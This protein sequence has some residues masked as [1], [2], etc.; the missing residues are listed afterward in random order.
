MA[1]SIQLVVQ[2]APDAA[3]DGAELVSDAGGGHPHVARLDL[4]EEAF[5][6]RAEHVQGAVEGSCGWH[7]VRHVF[8][9]VRARAHAHVRQVRVDD[10]EFEVAGGF[11][12]AVALAEDVCGEGGGGRGEEEEAGE[13]VRGY[14]VDGG[15]GD[16][17][18]GV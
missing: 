2:T 4:V 15:G 11:Q 12:D 16:V 6:V 8:G 3:G 17:G 1:A 10:G 18:E 9:D 7:R 5:A 13:V 14:H